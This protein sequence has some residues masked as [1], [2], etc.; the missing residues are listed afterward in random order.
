[1]Q[2][3]WTFNIAYLEPQTKD[4]IFPQSLGNTVHLGTVSS[5]SL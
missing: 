4:N 1:M 3:K 2:L 5:K